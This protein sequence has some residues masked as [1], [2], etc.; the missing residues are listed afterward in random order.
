MARYYKRSYKNYE[1]DDGA[2]FI[3][4][5]VIFFIICLV[6]AYNAGM[7]TFLATLASEVALI[8]LVIVGIKALKKSKENARKAKVENI[9]NT[10][11]KAGL[12]EY[13]NNFISR[14][15]LGQEKDKNVWTRRNYKISWD[16]INDLKDFL[17][18]KEIDFSS[19]EICILLANY[20]DKKEFDLTVNSIGATTNS[21]SKLSGTD[22]EHLLYRL[23]ETMGYSVL[24]NGK[25]GDQGGDLIATKNQERILIQAKCYKD[26]SVGNSAVQEAVAARN[27]Y[28]CNKAMVIT[29][30]VFTKEATELAKTNKVE[31]IPKELLQ[32]MLLDNL[33][34]SWSY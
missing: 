30:S 34:E 29:T 33:K 23:Y 15:G 19:S 3:V 5:I 27:H 18:Q 8:V 21:F 12:E 1:E 16:R 14:F 9:L 10:I 26:W 11:Q 28:D 22:F 20:I 24:S 17:Y 32:K 25:T 4:G 7:S 6:L 31:L 13:I 2:K